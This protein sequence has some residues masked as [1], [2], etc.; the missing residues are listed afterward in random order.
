MV[1]NKLKV[2]T[3]YTEKH[4]TDN[5]ITINCGTRKCLNCLKCYKN[6]NI[7]IINELLK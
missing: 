1:K 4:A 3:V 2:F 5:N 7:V 6:N